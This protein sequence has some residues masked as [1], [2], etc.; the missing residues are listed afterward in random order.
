MCCFYS[1]FHIQKKYLQV[2]VFARTWGFKSPIRTK[3]KS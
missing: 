3:L 1:L 2:L